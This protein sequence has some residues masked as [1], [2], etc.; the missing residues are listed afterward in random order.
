M[1]QLCLI[2]LRGNVFMR[3]HTKIVW[4]PSKNVS[5]EDLFVGV[6]VRVLAFSLT[7]FDKVVGWV[8]RP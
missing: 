1:A 8:E 4:Y 7:E 5:L 3:L 2:H 6:L